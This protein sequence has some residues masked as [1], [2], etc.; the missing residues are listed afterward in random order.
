LGPVEGAIL[1]VDPDE[2]IDD[3]IC[4]NSSRRPTLLA[5]WQVLS[6]KDSWD[7]FR[8]SKAFQVSSA[9]A[10]VLSDNQKTFDDFWPG[11]LI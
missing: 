5:R 2:L 10:F 1:A 7:S 8:K 11:P 9:C 6:V 4:L 3:D